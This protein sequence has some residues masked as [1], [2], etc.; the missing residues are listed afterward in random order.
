MTRSH[1]LSLLR[2]EFSFNETRPKW[3]SGGL[4]IRTPPP[5]EAKLSIS[6]VGVSRVR[7]GMDRRGPS[8]STEI[9]VN[10]EE[11]YIFTGIHIYDA[12]GASEY[13]ASRVDRRYTH[14][15]V[16]KIIHALVDS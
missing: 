4:G 8:H 2:P 6:G 1:V 5:L 13:D 16:L 12:K 10:S 11:A 15:V 14:T 3:R 9:F 7:P